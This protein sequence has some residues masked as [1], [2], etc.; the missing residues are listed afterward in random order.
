MVTPKRTLLAAAVAVAALFIGMPA[1][2]ADLGGQDPSPTPHPKQGNG[3][4]SGAQY[5]TSGSCELYSNSSSFGYSCLSGDGVVTT[6]EDVLKG[7]PVPTCWDERIS[8]EDAANKYDI[9]LNDGGG[10]YYRHRCLRGINPKLS[11]YQTGVQLSEVIIPIPGGHECKAPPGKRHVYKDADFEKCVFTLTHNQQMLIG[12]FQNGLAQIPGITIVT[13]PS[14]KV[15][16]NVV[17]AFRNEGMTDG[18]QPD[19]H[20]GRF[21]VETPHIRAG[22]VELW[23]QLDNDTHAP[24]QGVIG[25]PAQPGSGFAMWPTG[26]NAANPAQGRIRCDGSLPVHDNSAKSQQKYPSACWYTYHRSSADKPGQAY[27]FHAAATWTV[28]YRNGAGV[29]VLGHYTKTY[30]VPLPV[31]D[32]QVLNTD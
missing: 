29:H 26:Y 12:Y 1:A 24:L 13:E 17:T 32:V 7:D 15:R 8:A 9:D 2:F 19:D 31:R 20:G 27:A 16:T 14:L 11:V 28:Y 21:E 3:N 5:T 10:P 30:D 18:Y 4:G 23:A 25:A 22:G 6:V